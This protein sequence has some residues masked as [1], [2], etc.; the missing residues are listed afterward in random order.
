MIRAFDGSPVDPS[1]LTELCA[2][3]LRAPTAGNCAGVSMV[4]VPHHRVEDYFSVATDGH[5]RSNA[6]RAPGLT[7]AGAVVVVL[8]N[9][10]QYAARYQEADKRS[11]GL[12]DVT[13]WPVPYWHGDAAMATMALLLLLT[14]AGLGATFWGVFRHG[15]AIATLVQAPTDSV[16]FGSVLV[17]V[18]APQDDPTSK[19]LLRVTPRRRDRVRLLGD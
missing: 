3:A 18:A 9:P 6:R 17:G 19:S 13:A 7:R 2:E 5:W 11:S 14:E 1:Q 4:I 10:A 12:G 8:C 16:V 15:E